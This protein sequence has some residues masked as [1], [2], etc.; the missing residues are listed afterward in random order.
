MRLKLTSLYKADVVRRR[1]F[2]IFS[3]Q[4]KALFRISCLS[5][6]IDCDKTEGH[7]IALL[8]LEVI[9]QAPMAIADHVDA[10]VEALFNSRK[11]AVNKLAS[12]A[13]VRGGDSVFGYQ[14]FATE[15][16]C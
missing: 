6:S 2:I 13:I 11:G 12:A 1:L 3:Q 7:R 9:K 10:V 5:L 8:P 15:I 14:Y 16:V 4:I